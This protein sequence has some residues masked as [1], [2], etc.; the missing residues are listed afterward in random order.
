MDPWAVERTASG[1][2]AVPL[3]T[4]NEHKARSTGLIPLRII[5]DADRVGTC[6]GIHGHHYIVRT[7]ALHQVERNAIGGHIESDDASIGIVHCLL[8]R[9]DKTIGVKSRSG[10]CESRRI[11]DGYFHETT[12][13]G[14]RAETDLDIPKLCVSGQVDAGSHRRTIVSKLRRDLGKGD[15]GHSSRCG[16]DVDDEH[17]GDDAKVEDTD[18]DDDDDDDDDE[19]G[20]P[21]GRR[22]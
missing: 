17:E 16:N 4:N 9:C 14:H 15:S 6:I 20:K 8:R 7:H 2:S 10:T 19:D 21:P 11:I 22:R 13:N 18:S 1:I 3:S 5:G 12:W